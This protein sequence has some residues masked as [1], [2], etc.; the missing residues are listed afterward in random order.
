MDSSRPMVTRFN[1]NDNK[2]VKLMGDILPVDRKEKYDSTWQAEV[3]YFDD[4]AL[5]V[6]K[7]KH[8]KSPSNF[9]GYI[10]Y[11][12]CSD[13]DGMCIPFETDFVFKY[14]FCRTNLQDL[15]FIQN[16]NFTI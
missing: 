14:F 6:Q 9:S 11:Q 15:A 12:V 8:S 5:F 3:T 7:I 16:Y 10:S 2:V 1:F 4:S 13:I